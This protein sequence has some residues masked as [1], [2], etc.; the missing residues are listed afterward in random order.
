[1]VLEIKTFP[2]EILRKVAEKVETIDAELLTLLDNMLETL[3]AAP[4]YG[5]AAPQ[6][7]VSKR[8]IIIDDSIGKKEGRVFELINPEII[9]SSGEINEEEG[10]LSIPGE[11]A[12]VKRF[13]D[14][15]VKYLDRTG[16]ECIYKS[17]TTLFARIV[18]HEIDHL[19]GHLFIDK[20]SSLKRD[21]IKKS[22]KKRV[23]DGDYIVTT[24]E[25]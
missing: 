4:G 17:E 6:V 21:S 24:T 5:I 11:Y 14:I 1:M 25:V 2:D 9:E 13:T 8:I 22:I 12:Y 15:T 3:Y 7:G 23:K 19:N 20:L 18:Q 16:K 10:C